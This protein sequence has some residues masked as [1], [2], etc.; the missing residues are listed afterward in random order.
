VCVCVF[1]CVHAGDK[2]GLG[3]GFGAL[4]VHMTRF[5][6]RFSYMHIDVYVQGI[7]EGL[8]WLSLTLAGRK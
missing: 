2:R 1:V 8:D 6:T 7:N 5:M 3:L 4:C